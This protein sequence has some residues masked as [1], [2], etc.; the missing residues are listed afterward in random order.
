[1][2]I[3]YC[4]RHGRVAEWRGKPRDA[5]GG[6]NIEFEDGRPRDAGRLLE[7]RCM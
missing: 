4:S 1:M 2:R 3:N 6:L 5:E 7:V